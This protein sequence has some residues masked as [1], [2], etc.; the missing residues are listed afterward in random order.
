MDEL[1]II[2]LAF[3]FSLGIAFLGGATEMLLDRKDRKYC[4]S[5]LRQTLY[6]KWP[7]PTIEIFKYWYKSQISE[8]SDHVA[9]IIKDI[10]FREIP[11]NEYSNFLLQRVEESNERFIFVSDTLNPDVYCEEKVIKATGEKTNKGVKFI[12]LCGRYILTRGRESHDFLNHFLN[13]RYKATM[14]F[15]MRMNRPPAL[16]YK[17]VDD[18]LAIIEI[19]HDNKAEKRTIWETEDKGI[20][21]LLLKKFE[22][23]I[24]EDQTR[25]VKD[26]NEYKLVPEF[27]NEY[28]K[29]NLKTLKS[30]GL[31]KASKNP[32][33]WSKECLIGEYLMINYIKKTSC[34]CPN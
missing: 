30:R 33:E 16:H 34:S 24:N 1:T 27:P 21:E 25:Q 26:I 31:D 9:E 14:S 12:F 8:W 28:M 29:A 18:R 32:K 15:H 22:T 10:D 20:V 2:L 4:L 17:I 11:L 3:L 7:K 19:L 6:E 5:A 13:D 23:C